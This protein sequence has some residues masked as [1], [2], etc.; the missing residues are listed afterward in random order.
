MKGQESGPHSHR[1]AWDFFFS[2]AP[3]SFL[4]TTQLTGYRIAGSKEDRSCCGHSRPSGD[5]LK[6]VQLPVHSRLW[7]QVAL[8]KDDSAFWLCF[9]MAQQPLA[10]QDLLIV[11]ASRSHSDTPHSTPLVEWSSETETSTWQNSEDT[12]FHNPDGIWTHKPS[13]WVAADPHLRDF[14]CT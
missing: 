12:D 10:D 5:E 6:W 11:E 3:R 13:N 8:F 4:E 9:S 14:N 1:D 7:L 2:E